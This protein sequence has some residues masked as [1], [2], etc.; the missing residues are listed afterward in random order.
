ME[1]GTKSIAGEAKRLGNELDDIPTRDTDTRSKS[2]SKPT[3]NPDRVKSSIDNKG[4]T[5]K[6][7]SAF[8]PNQNMLG[9]KSGGAVSLPNNNDKK[10][11]SYIEDLKR[12]EVERA[13]KLRQEEAAT[14]AVLSNMRD[15]PNSHLFQ[16]HNEVGML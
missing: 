8:K 5:N 7:K 12:Q 13:V 4:S 9:A 3:Y 11:A 15:N 10:A 16:M 14:Q 2:R 6:V 1:N